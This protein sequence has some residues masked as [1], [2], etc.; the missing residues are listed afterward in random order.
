MQTLQ[1]FPNFREHIMGNL[2]CQGGVQWAKRSGSMIAGRQIQAVYR[3]FQTV[4]VQ[5]ALV[6]PQFSTPLGPIETDENALLTAMP[7]SIH[8]WKRLR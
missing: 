7:G 2:A 1:T 3:S 4:S 8:T 6:I 5:Q